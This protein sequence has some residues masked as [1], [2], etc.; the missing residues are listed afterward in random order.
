[1]R[2]VQSSLQT[3]GFDGIALERAVHPLHA[4]RQGPVVIDD[5]VEAHLRHGV[6]AVKKIAIAHLPQI[7]AARRPSLLRRVGG[8]PPIQRVVVAHQVGFENDAGGVGQLPADHGRHAIPFGIGAVPE[9][10]AALGHGVQ[11]VGQLAFGIQRPG[12]VDGRAPQALIAELAADRDSGLRQGLLGHDV[13]G[14]ARIAASIQG[15]GRATHDF[16]PLDGGCVGRRGVAAIDGE[17]VAIELA[18][19]KAAC[20]EQGQPLPAK[21]VDP[22]HA[23]CVIEDVDQP[24]RGCIFHHVT[25]QDRHGLRRFLQRRIGARGACRPGGAIP[26]NGVIGRLAGRIDGDCV[27]LHGGRSARG[28]LSPGK[29]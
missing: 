6:V 18:A 13:E 24:R 28:L 27:Q 3:I 29:R 23:A 26:R 25:W 2:S 14:A 10:L 8:P 21:V 7:D 19:G 5:M 22:A 20:A 4:A 16:Q 12:C 9:G 11:P 15:R 1:V 17:A